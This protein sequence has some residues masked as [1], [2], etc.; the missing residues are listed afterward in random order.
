MNLGLMTAICA[1]L[2]AQLGDQAVPNGVEES[3]IGAT[4]GVILPKGIL[5][6]FSDFLVGKRTPISRTA[7]HRT[8][9]DDENE[10]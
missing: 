8:R 6:R 5:H 9:K 7:A 3:A 2:K 4:E 1:N 10:V